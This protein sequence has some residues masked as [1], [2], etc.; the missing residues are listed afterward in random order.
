M[1]ADWYIS[2]QQ[3]REESGIET[4]EEMVENKTG[5]LIKTMMEHKN[6]MQDLPEEQTLIRIQ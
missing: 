3:I 1:N 5:N 2:N 4:L 6:Q